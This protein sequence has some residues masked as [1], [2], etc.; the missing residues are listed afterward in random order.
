MHQSHLSRLDRLSTLLRLKRLKPLPTLL[1]GALGERNYTTSHGENEHAFFT[2]DVTLNDDGEVTECRGYDLRKQLYKHAPQIS[3]FVIAYGRRRMNEILDAV[4]RENVLN[5][6]TDG[7][8]VSVDSKRVE[9]IRALCDDTPRLGGLKFENEGRL[10][11]TH[12]NKWQ[13][14]K[15]YANYERVLKKCGR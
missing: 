11:L 6:Q 14:L 1:W 8:L 9:Q 15:V 13:M 3:L 4:G 12:V 5:V 10:E 2:H 7:C